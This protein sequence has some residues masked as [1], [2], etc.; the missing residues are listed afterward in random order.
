MAEADAALLPN[1]VQE[2]KISHAL[3]GWLNCIGWSPHLCECGPDSL[4]LELT[5][6][7][8]RSKFTA[9]YGQLSSWAR[10]SF[11]LGNLMIMYH[12]VYESFYLAVDSEPSLLLCSKGD[13]GT[14]PEHSTQ[15]TL[16]GCIL[17]R[18]VLMS[19]DSPIEI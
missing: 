3:I 10:A 1:A 9:S 12:A 6:L 2:L 15:K 17:R 13:C 18:Y 11:V 5:E 4:G 19:N 14:F 8:H 16:P 7:G